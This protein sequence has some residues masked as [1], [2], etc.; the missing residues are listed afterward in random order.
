MN[1]NM[2]D[3]ALIA[4]DRALPGLGLL[5]EP[6][7]LLNRLH[8]NLVS[9]EIRHLKINYL[10]YKPG[11][12]C[13]AGLTLTL[14]DGQ[15][16]LCYAKAMTP[17]RFQQSWQH[18]RRQALIAKAHPHAPQ[19]LH[20]EAILLQYPEFDFSIRYLSC[21]T[22]DKKRMDLLQKLLPGNPDACILR[23]RFLRYKPERRAVIALTR[24]DKPQAV[25]RIANAKEFERILQGC[26]I[27]TALGHLS[28]AGFD[29]SRRALATHWLAGQS[30]AP[31][32]GAPLEAE[33]LTAVGRELARLH[34]TPLLPPLARQGEE[35]AHTLRDVFNTFSAI[36]PSGADRFLALMQRITPYLAASNS[37]PVL[38]HGDFS[39]DQIV[40][41]D[42]G[43]LRFIDWDRCCSGNALADIASFQAR[44]EMQVITGLLD[45]HQAVNAIDALLAGY[46]SQR[47][48][49]DGLVWYSAS[50]LLCLATEP[51]RL[52]V[53][54]WA[55]QTEALLARAAQLVEKG[56]EKR[57]SGGKSLE[58][59]QRLA[60]LSDPAFISQPL[61]QALRLPA[62]SQL[63]Q[64]LLR[65]H[66]PGRRALIEYQFSLPDQSSR[67]IIGKYRVKGMDRHA[68][69]CQQALW[70]HGFDATAA[71]AVP[72][73]LATLPDWHLWLQ[74][75][76]N[77]TPLT[78]WLQPGY[79]RLELSGNDVGKA[80]AVLQQNEALRQVTE[81]RKWTLEDELEVL[82]KGLQHV[83]SDYPQW[84]ERLSQLF[85]AC[86][87]L[88]ASLTQAITRSVHRDFYPD[89]VMINHHQPQQVIL[90]D[91]DLCCQSFAALDAGNYLA[92]VEELALRHY[93]AAT[94][95]DRHGQAFT[96]A[97]LAHSADVA[98]ADIEKFTVL[99]LARHIFL[100]T[101]FPERTH[102]TLPLLERCEWLL[103]RQPDTS[104][105]MSVNQG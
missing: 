27:G 44:L 22:D 80:L 74:E 17:S 59:Q 54:S 77:A 33:T 61:L 78:A 47:S 55:Q 67:S 7:R 52:R 2:H 94:A 66:K 41:T 96:R 56:A 19:A 83:A 98:I 53:P 86:Q 40:K 104:G 95:L 16:Q 84:Q 42:T 105:N 88:A 62:G 26:S 28:L 9:G 103:N 68:F 57:L 69:R 34:Q 65:R 72:Q 29:R 32:S 38:L 58:P 76:V 92:H 51:F 37:A 46:Q 12:S 5:L 43:D 4:N 31:E 101:R 18:P 70:Q 97:F 14:A 25:V 35:D 10:R 87:T 73:P 30:L 100:S 102:T 20:D 85:N 39:A 82:Q 71:I 75:K 89:Q 93:G 64:C 6:H 23:S 21:L 13:V 1:M 3:A 49:P 50:A 90:V 11:T 91:F 45:A 63:Q 60:A 48:L 15:E 8:A 81:T 24:H 99:S 79:P 36:Y